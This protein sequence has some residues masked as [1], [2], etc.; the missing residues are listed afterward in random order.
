M[1][2]FFTNFLTVLI[3]SSIFLSPGCANWALQHDY[4]EKTKVEKQLVQLKADHDLA[5]KKAIDDLR[6]SYDK[7]ISSLNGQLQGAANP[8][9]GAASAFKYYQS[10]S[11]LDVIINNRVTEA[12]AA[13]GVAPTYEAIT[14]ENERLVKELDETKTTMEELTK[15]H[16]DMVAANSKLNEETKMLVVK[17]EQQKK[18]IEDLNSK[19]AADLIKKQDEISLIKDKLLSSE[20]QRADEQASIE[21]LKRNLMIVCGAVALLALAGAIYSPIGKRGLVI[22]AGI[23]G[24]A[25][26]AIPFI[27]GTMILI[28]VSICM[29]II[30]VYFLYKHNLSEKTNTNLIGGISDI[31]DKVNDEAKS[32]IKTTLTD[33]NGKYEMNKLGNV[34]T[35]VDNSVE[36]YIT[37]KL[38]DLKKF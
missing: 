4:V 18:A 6:T 31:K 22:I 15:T 23:C 17:L 20:K 16:N 34:V 21:R 12:Q 5:L 29:V 9:Y 25:A 13:L 11:R 3:I 36:K 30:T 35:K 27:T 33:W 14:K 38:R 10:P 1:K 32:I 24:G 8:L 19:F 37:E 2:T 26:V 7:L 28:A